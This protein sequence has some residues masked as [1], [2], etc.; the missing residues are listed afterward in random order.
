MKL[1]K[2]LR[3]FNPDT[4][5]VIR[6]VNGEQNNTVPMLYGLVKDIPLNKNAIETVV[7]LPDYNECAYITL[8]NM[9]VTQISE[10][11]AM[12]Y[13]KSSMSF[14]A[15]MLF[16][17]ITLICITVSDNP[18]DYSSNPDV[19]MRTSFFISIA[20]ELEAARKERMDTKPS[21]Q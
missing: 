9:K 20:K 14:A 3:M 1:K 10:I 2:L 8:G 12:D 18:Q 6:T 15:T 21:F 7:V 17:G 19:K 13:C 4:A 5:I 16:S 11:Y